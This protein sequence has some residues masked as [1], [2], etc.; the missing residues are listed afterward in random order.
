MHTTFRALFL[1]AVF[2]STLPA[3]G[4]GLAL[5]TLIP[6]GDLAEGA[7]SGFTGIASLELNLVSRL[8]LRAEALWANSDLDGAIIKGSGGVSV[9][10]NAAVSGDVRLVGGLASLTYT[11]SEGFLRP[12]L[13][14]GA[15]YYRR[16]VSQSASGAAGDLA[17]LDRDESQLGLHAG[18]GIHFG[19][20]GVTAFGEARYH[21]V[22]TGDGKTNFVPVL[23]GLR[24]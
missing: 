2:A 7:K 10:D 14:G 8:A 23:V 19:L 21:S 3:Q 24:F 15:G 9:P 20:L 12:Y 13:L 4:L 22:N 18:V 16:S 1:V 17:K 11:L 5:G 6:Q